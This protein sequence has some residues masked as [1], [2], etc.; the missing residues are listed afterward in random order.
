M[1]KEITVLR[2]EKNQLRTASQQIID[3]AKEESRA[4]T[5]EE[6]KT[7]DENKV[8]MHQI[9]LDIEERLDTMHSQHNI[10]GKKESKQFSIVRAIRNAMNG[11]AQDDAEA[12]VLSRAAD[13]QGEIERIGSLLVPFGTRAAM[14]G[15]GGATYGGVSTED[16]AFVLPLENNLALSAAGAQ[17]LTGLKGNVRFP[18]MSDITVAW[19]AENDSASD[20]G[21]EVSTALSL[22][23]KR[24]CAY[25][26]ISK[27]LLIQENQDVEG[28]VRKLFAIAVAQKLEATALG[29][30][31]A[32]DGPAGIFYTKPSIKGA[33]SYGKLV[34]M[35]TA[36]NTAGGLKDSLAY[37]LHPTLWGLAKQTPCHPSTGA[38][39][40]I[41]GPD[42]MINGY[43]SFSTANCCNELE[44]TAAVGSTPAVNAG[45]AAVFGNWSDFVIANWG[46]LDL[47]I[48]ALSQATAGKVRIVLNSYWN[49]GMLHA[50]SFK[51]AAL[52]IPV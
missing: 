13:R 46:N 7:L 14:T 27:Q 9:D 22:A 48:D 45:Y 51:T 8:R 3:K 49:Y 32:G 35:E 18:A 43:K 23:P 26:D 42:N 6:T 47:T 4:L 34:D 5:A 36:V 11:T 21:S 24:L 12:E 30:A 28:Y 38:G 16:R 1:G 10:E 50:G 40:L 15:G 25:V 39:G 41:L 19:D 33:F 2:D 29:K 37:I 52:A 17:M 20:G 44:S 31:A